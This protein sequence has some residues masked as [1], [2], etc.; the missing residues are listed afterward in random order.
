MRS[1]TAKENH[2]GSAVSKIL[3]YRQTDSHPP[4]WMT[5]FKDGILD[6]NEY[7]LGQHNAIKSNS[8]RYVMMS[9]INTLNYCTG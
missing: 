2:I 4:L 7:I 1:Y 3:R 9:Y 8:P 6:K 5:N